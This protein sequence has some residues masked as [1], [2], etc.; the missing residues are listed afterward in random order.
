MTVNQIKQE[1][2]KKLKG[3]TYKSKFEILTNIKVTIKECKCYG[4]LTEDEA[5]IL[6]IYVKNLREELR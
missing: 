2:R 5:E 4:I 3:K 1:I 6:M